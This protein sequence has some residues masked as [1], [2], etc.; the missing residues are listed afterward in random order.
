MTGIRELG[1]DELSQIAGGMS[2]GSFAI[3]LVN[4]LARIASTTVPSSEK[5]ATPVTTVTSSPKSASFD[6]VA[7]R[8]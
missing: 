6:P 5:P 4:G 7:V 3:R 2:L 8:F 1:N